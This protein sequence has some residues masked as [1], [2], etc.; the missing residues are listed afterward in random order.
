M[1]DLEINLDSSSLHP[2]YLIL[3]LILMQT[4][5]TSAAT[6]LIQ[7]LTIIYPDSCNNLLTGFSASSLTRS[8]LF[9][10][11]QRFLFSLRIKAEVPTMASDLSTS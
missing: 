4:L 9:S 10:T 5:I 8:S 7:A 6:T 11:S 1:D 2:P 3:W